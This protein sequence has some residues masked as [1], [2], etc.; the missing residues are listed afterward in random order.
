MN[1][2][3][4]NQVAFAKAMADET[5]STIML[6]LC[7]VWLN[8]NDIVEK[9]DG[10]VNQPTVSHHLKKLEEAGFVHTREEGKYRFYTLN[11]E[12]VR[13]CCGI[14]QTNFKLDDPSAIVPIH[15]IPVVGE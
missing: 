13:F 7:C 8:V 2:D 4:I 9:L 6:Q 10:K 1:N 11:L 14:L 12:R 3:L 15:T 5:R